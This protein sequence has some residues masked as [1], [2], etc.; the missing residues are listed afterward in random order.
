[1]EGAKLCHLRDLQ[2]A[3]ATLEGDDF[4]TWVQDKKAWYAPLE[5]K[6]KS[7][8]KQSN[9]SKKATVSIS[10]DSEDE[11]E[12]ERNETA[13]PAAR[14]RGCTRKIPAEM[15]PN[16]C[17]ATLISKDLVHH[18]R[19]SEEVF[20]SYTTSDLRICATDFKEMERYTSC[21]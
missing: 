16:L 19:W 12:H 4:K 17:I 6:D 11:H 14:G 10:S 18:V 1:M 2:K 8:N 5:R 9:N 15:R 20:K 13:R 21:A 3:C 7:K